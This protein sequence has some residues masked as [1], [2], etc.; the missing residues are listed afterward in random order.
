MADWNHNGKSDS[1]DGYMDYKMSGGASG[2]SGGGL[3][4]IWVALLCYALATELSK[5]WSGFIIV[6]FI[7][8]IVAG[9]KGYY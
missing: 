4:V 1:S 6:M 3:S 5:I 9:L 8:F 7:V 2:G